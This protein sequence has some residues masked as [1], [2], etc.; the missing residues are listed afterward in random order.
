MLCTLGHLQF[1]IRG[2][3]EECPSFTC[4]S[5]PGTNIVVLKSKICCSPNNVIGSE[6][7]TYHKLIDSDQSL[8]TVMTRYLESS[9]VGLI[10]IN[11]TNR[12]SLPDNFDS[13][14]GEVS[15]TLPVYVV[16]LED[17][18]KLE[19]FLRA[20]KEE[21]VEVTV[22][23]DSDVDLVPMNHGVPSPDMSPQSL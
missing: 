11:T 14:E 5:L 1:C 8:S 6:C 3:Q 23:F 16:S 10:I 20:R 21:F 4:A 17:G 2:S 7:V 9:L 13:S 18:E 19:E 15:L 22:V 12:L